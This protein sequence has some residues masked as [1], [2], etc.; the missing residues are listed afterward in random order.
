ML[1]LSKTHVNSAPASSSSLNSQQYF[2]LDGVPDS[3]AL[4][5]VEQP[6]PG[7]GT[8]P[9]HTPALGALES[10]GKLGQGLTNQRNY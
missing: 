7:Q 2:S 1:P 9:V 4:S 3:S 6:E 5:S 8:V 10:R